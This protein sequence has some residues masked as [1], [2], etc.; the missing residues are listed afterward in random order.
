MKF[1]SCI[2]VFVGLILVLVLH[3]NAGI[4]TPTG[5]IITYSTSHVSYPGD[6]A[7]DGLP[8]NNYLGR[9][10]AVANKLPNVYV[11]YQFT[12]GLSYAVDSYKIWNQTK[13]EVVARAPKNFSLL[14]SSNGTDWV[15][16]DT[17]TNQTGWTDAEGRLYEFTNTVEYSYFKLLIAANNGD[18]DYCGL[19]EIELFAPSMTAPLPATN[20]SP[21]DG[22]TGV[23]NKVLLQWTTGVYASTNI[24][25]LST[26]STIT[27]DERVAYFS[28]E[29]FDP[30]YLDFS[31]TYHWRVDGI[32]DVGLTT[33]TVWQFTTDPTPPAL[34][35]YEGF[36]G[37]TV[38]AIDGQGGAEDG[39]TTQWYSYPEVV[40]TNSSLSYLN[41]DV[42]IDGGTQSVFFSTLDRD[43]LLRRMFN[44]QTNGPVYFSLL[45]QRD[46][47]STSNLFSVGVK[48]NGVG[49]DYTYSS[50]INFGYPADEINAESYAYQGAVRVSAGVAI[51]NNKT[52]FLVAK[53][54]REGANLQF[55][56]SSVLVNPS[57]LT[58]P[59]TG[60]TS[61]VKDDNVA[62][63][64]N[65]F[66]FRSR[67]MQTGDH[68]IVDE[69][70]I[71]TTYEGVV[72]C[73]PGRGS[74]FLIK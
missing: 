19:S 9:W 39:W 11:T 73:S 36:E 13:Y 17:R 16:L 65:R 46:S 23:R 2:K 32:N 33:G 7:Y 27:E 38:G 70:R 63:L 28:Q 18:P 47:I 44:V 3:V 51:E 67:F 8:V 5:G 74:V 52:Y 15:T 4:T 21:M 6:N 59:A 71:G 56:K 55:Y 31:T 20:P 50:G 35:A 58:E 72:I 40:V 1:N 25:Y 61:A 42:Y 29:E 26:D 48:E 45:I 49:E 68:Y 62:N 34:V 43:E 54:T 57:T 60:W 24:V 30:G 14:A 10:L 69:I 64:L 22:A 41:E 66:G 12:N 53:V 37:R